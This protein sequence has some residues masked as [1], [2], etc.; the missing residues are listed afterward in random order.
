MLSLKPSKDVDKPG[1]TGALTL[2]KRPFKTKTK[3]KM[4]MTRKRKLL[5]LR[6]GSARPPLTCSSESF[7]SAQEQ[8]K[9]STMTK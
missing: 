9:P 3:M 8:W 2:T 4:M 5:P 6:L 1:V 7:F